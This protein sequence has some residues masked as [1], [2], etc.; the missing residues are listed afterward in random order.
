M[1]GITNFAAIINP[2]QAGIL[3]C[4]N[5]QPKVVVDSDGAVKQV[6]SESFWH[7][8]GNTMDSVMN[9]VMSYMPM[10]VMVMNVTMSCDHRVVDGAVGAKWL[11]TFKSLIE[12]PERLLL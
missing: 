12:N 6:L 9:S 11:Q 5:A 10:Q 4:G 8:D 1:Y 2:P 3:A 7:G